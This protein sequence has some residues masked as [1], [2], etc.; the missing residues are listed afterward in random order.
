MSNVGELGEFL[1]VRRAALQPDDVGLRSFGL[2]RV[3]GLR[4]EEIALLAGVS[5]TYYARLEQGLSTNASDSVIEALGRAL[6]LN[7]DERVHLK[8]LACPVKRTRRAP[9]KPDS[10]R[11][12]IARLIRSMSTT[13]AVVLGRRSE[14]LAWNL[15]GTGWWPVIS[16]SMRR[17]TRQRGRI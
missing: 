12:G 16:I 5:S 9:R 10:V 11:P 6:N 3:P 7:D 2:R 17:T 4:R 8:N 15:W 1:R 14:V 13:P